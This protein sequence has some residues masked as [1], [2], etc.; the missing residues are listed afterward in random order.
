MARRLREE[1]WSESGPLASLSEQE[2]A[3]VEK[4]A[5]EAAGMFTRSSSCVEGLN[6]RLSLHRHGQGPLSQDKLNA[7]VANHN[8]LKKD[9]DG[10]T[11]AERFTGVK[12]R[13]AFLWLLERV[14]FIKLDRWR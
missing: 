13:D 1:A 10:S 3:V 8:F 12:Q 11:A 7:L 4:T 14:V 2:K 5:V 9:K 6:G